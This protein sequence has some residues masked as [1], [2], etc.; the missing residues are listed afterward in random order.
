MPLLQ[1]AARLELLHEA[2]SYCYVDQ[3]GV[4]GTGDRIVKQ[5]YSSFDAFPESSLYTSLM[6]EFQALMNEALFGSANY[7]FTVPLQFNWMVLQR[8][9]PGQL[10]LTPHRD[11]YSA[12]N[13]VCIFNIDGQGKF[14]VCADRKGT[15]SLEIDTTPGNVI[16]LK[17]PGFLL[18]NRRPFHYLTDIRSTRY[19]FGL[20]QRISRSR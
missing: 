9:E 17:A 5:E 12:I 2:K 8:Y 3:T 15:N 7:P 19:S 4:V 14:Y 18:S 16:F 1:E 13:L 20:R 6:T 11:S 10:G